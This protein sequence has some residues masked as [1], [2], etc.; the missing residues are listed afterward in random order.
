MQL[1][2]P[3]LFVQMII[4]PGPLMYAMISSVMQTI[5]AKQNVVTTPPPTGTALQKR[6]I[7]W[8]IFRHTRAVA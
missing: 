2:L 8:V 3:Y 7:V 1:Q 4:H 6:A 5:I